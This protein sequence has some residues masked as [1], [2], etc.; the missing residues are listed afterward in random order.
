MQIQVMTGAGDPFETA[1]NGLGWGGVAGHR[2]GRG[3]SSGG[4]RA[5]TDG[6][7][8]RG[9]SSR[10]H[11]RTGADADGRRPPVSSSAPTPSRTACCSTAPANW[12]AWC[13][14]RTTVAGA[15]VAVTDVRGEVPATVRTDGL[16][17]FGLTGPAPGT[18]TFAGSSPEHRPLR[19][20]CGDQRP[21][22][23][24]RGRLPAPGHRGDRSGWTSSMTPANS[25]SRHG[26][27]RSPHRSAG[28]GVRRARG[29]LRRRRGGRARYRGRC[30][31]RRVRRAGRFG[32]AGRA[33]A[34]G[35][36]HQR[37]HGG[38]RRHTHHGPARATR[39]GRTS[40]VGG[41]RGRRS[42]GPTECAGSFGG[43]GSDIW[44]KWRPPPR[45]TSDPAR[46]CRRRPKNFPR[47]P[48]PSA[49][50]SPAASAVPRRP[51]PRR[52]GSGR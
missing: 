43:S 47:P 49:P 39:R 21:L 20:A 12:P 2:R 45:Q 32:R 5:G 50:F 42:A 24:H 15:M 14:P 27:W 4:C 7:R 46:G 44:S 13:G 1:A 48:S 11:R 17:E 16:G 10:G 41:R 22:H 29:G 35:E 23:A 37:S 52:T 33:A 6:R 31:G 18:V 9:G 51:G 26:S 8:R 40:A 25:A 34:H 30:A 38:Q 36:E 19:P 28:S 3:G